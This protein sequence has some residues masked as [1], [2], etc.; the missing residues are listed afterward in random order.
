[1]HERHRRWPADGTRE[2][3]LQ[4]LGRPCAAA[5]SV[6]SIASQQSGIRPFGRSARSRARWSVGEERTCR[7]TVDDATVVKDRYVVGVLGQVSDV[8]GG[9]KCA[10]F[11]REVTQDVAKH[12]ALLWIHACCGLIEEKNSRLMNQGCGHSHPPQLPPGKPIGLCIGFLDETNSGKRAVGS[13]PGF[14]ATHPLQPAHVRNIFASGQ[15]RHRGDGLR[16][17][18]YGPTVRLRTGAGSGHSPGA[19]LLAA[20]IAEDLAISRECGQEAAT[21]QGVCSG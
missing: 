15:R 6:P 7:S 20:G 16:H 19:A 10:D 4:L 1:M 13:I 8:M 18:G 11:T 2:R 3:P 9:H 5:V 14:A 21:D 12:S 17:P